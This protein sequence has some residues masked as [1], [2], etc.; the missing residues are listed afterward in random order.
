MWVRL[1]AVAATVAGASACIIG[2]KQDDP[3]TLIDPHQIADSGTFGTDASTGGDTG[4]STEDV[5]TIQPFLDSATPADSE[6]P[7]S[8]AGCLT[9]AA[10]DA[11]DAVPCDGGS[12]ALAS[13]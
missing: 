6:A 9:D 7:K 11:A 2:P 5:G 4:R 13:D 10:G 3:E 12:D 8:D 1:V